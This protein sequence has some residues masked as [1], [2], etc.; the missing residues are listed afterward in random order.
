MIIL[1][2]MGFSPENDASEN[3]RILQKAADI[4]G[5][6]YIDRSGTYDIDDTIVLKDNTSVIFCAGAVIRRQK[7]KTE[8]SYL[9]INEG[10]FTRKYNSNI[11]ILNLT[12]ICN[13]VV[14]ENITLESKKGVPGLNAHLAFSY[15]K[16]LY[17][18]NFQVYDLPA[19]DFAVQVCSFE[20]FM[21]E[22]S[23]IEGRKDGVHL[24]A[25]NKFAI[26]HCIFK[27]YDDPI[28]LN[29]HDY[30]T[31][32]PQ[33]GWI[34]NGIIEDCY[35][36][37]DNNGTTGFFCRVLAGSWLKWEK[38]MEVQHSDIVEYNNRLYRVFME[39]DGRIFKT[40]TPPTH[41]NGLAVYDGITWC[42][43][44]N[45][46]IENCGCRNIHFKDI[47]LQK[48]RPIAFSLHFDKDNFSRSYYPGSNAPVLDNIIF[49]NIYIQNDITTFLH[50]RTPVGNIKLINSELG[51]A[52]FIFK[53][54]ETEGI[55]YTK[56]NLVLSGVTFKDGIETLVSADEGFEITLS[57][58]SSIASDSFKPLTEGN[59]T[60]KSSDISLSIK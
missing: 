57:V 38:G 16:N 18:D 17:I 53:N 59:V 19:K 36:L 3:Y 33:M 26:R 24:G 56:T 32:N 51:G 11:R 12:L 27:T 44:Q 2:Q 1:S 54:I 20:N 5:D 8:T 47:F 25:G 43:V 42:M 14:S 35:D 41:E 15:I 58:S 23:R 50:A 9:F 55:V 48:K 34:E 7:N 29:A 6:I 22:N 21:I 40:L 45:E 37:D 60:V 52:G 49:E 31:S 28:A 39:P 46:V 10:A 4:G 30:A 13:D